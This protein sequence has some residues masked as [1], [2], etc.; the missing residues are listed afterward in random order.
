[1][2]MR[3]VAAVMSG[4]AGL[5]LGASGASGLSACRANPSID[6]SK[7]AKIGSAAAPPSCPDVCDRLV[8]LCGYAPV[9]CVESC[10]DFDDGHKVCLGQAAS[11]QDALQSCEDADED[12]DAGEDAANDDD[13]S[14][15]GE[16]GD[17]ASDGASGPD[18]TDAN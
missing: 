11:C 9:G 12:E 4:L 10:A 5:A 1:M 17:K 18:A 15:D 8:R 6:G 2:R 16:L 7:V 3:V 13:A 14:F